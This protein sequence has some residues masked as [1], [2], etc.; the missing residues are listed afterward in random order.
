M[1]NVVTCFRSFNYLLSQM[2]LQIY[3]FLN[4]VCFTHSRQKEKKIMNFLLVELLKGLDIGL[5]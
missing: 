4:I 5:I 3:I 1:Q 2:I